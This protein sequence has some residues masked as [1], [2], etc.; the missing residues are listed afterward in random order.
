MNTASLILSALFSPFLTGTAGVLL[1]G[2]TVEYHPVRGLLFHSLYSDRLRPFLSSVS[3]K[4]FDL[5]LRRLK[6]FSFVPVTAREALRMSS[7]SR[8]GRPV[9]LTFDD[10][11]RSFFTHALPIL[12]TLNMKVTLYPVAGYLGRP[13]TWDVL[14]AFSHLS[15]AEVRE[16]SALGHEIG[17]HGMTHADLV[18]LNRRDL[19]EELNGSKKLL[20][21][22]T[23][24]QVVSFS[25]PYGSWNRRVWDL[26]REAGYECGAIY[27]RHRHAPAGLFPVFGVYGIDTPQ[28]VIPRIMPHGPLSV[29]VAMARMISHFAKG[30]PVWKFDKKYRVGP[31]T[32]S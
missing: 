28:T 20:E 10:G 29:S 31:K 24:K 2:R 22:V 8:V 12:E 13:S 3:V 32:F 27:R 4:R 16:I 6:E 1:H 15:R 18:F 19:S 30:A 21:D 11:C 26:A 14:P 25:F 7:A 17:S 5:I 9:L 23:G